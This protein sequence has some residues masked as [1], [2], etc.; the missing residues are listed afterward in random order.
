LLS[1]DDNFLFNDTIFTVFQYVGFNY[2]NA[3]PLSVHANYTMPW[4]ALLSNLAVRQITYQSYN[5]TH[6][7]VNVQIV[8]E[9]HNQYVPVTGTMRIRVYNNQHV[10][11]GG[12]TVNGDVQPN[13]P[14]NV[15]AS[16]LVDNSR[17]TPTG[18]VRLYFTT[19]VF[20]Y[21]PVVKPY[22]ATS[23]VVP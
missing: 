3:I 13:S 1:Q 12:V 20:S 16:M 22:N 10:R 15:Q 5:S 4:G 11:M 14:G 2:A 23:G 17:I 18:E 21:G 8:F 9:N 19:S 6:S 7:T